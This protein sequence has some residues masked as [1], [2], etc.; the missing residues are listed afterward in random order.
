VRRES[1]ATGGAGRRVEAGTWPRYRDNLARHLIGVAR[2]LQGRVQTALAERC[3]FRGLRPSFAPF[4]GLLWEEGRPLREL[5]HEL[6]IS[7]QAAGQLADLVE[8]AGYLERRA[9]P[10]DRRSKL[11]RLTPRGRALVEQGVRL[12]LESETE[13]RALVGA[14]AFQR[15][16]RAL[17]ALYG[18]LGLAA[19]ADPR[20]IASAGRSIGVLPPIALRIEREL[21][22]ATLAR[23]HAGLKM[24]HGQVLP[25]IGPEGGRIH[26]IA[27]LQRVSRQAISATAVDLEARGY[28]RREP[29]PR[30]GRGVVLVLTSRGAALIRDS[31]AA[32]DELERRFRGLVGARRLDVL[33]EVARDLYRTLRLEAEIFGASSAPPAA[34][35]AQGRARG[36]REIE[37][38]ATRLRERLGSGDA[39]RLAALLEPP[40]RRTAP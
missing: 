24:S 35:R 31:V 33:R 6:A 22:E 16:T 8:A 1:P 17:A 27:R 38:L 15:F 11:V 25:L 3:G 10:G 5:A 2:D 21:M 4:L 30:D 29:D 40:A 23:G 19:P 9:N 39:A 14:G 32:L 28:L 20:L 18:G 36:R 34:P 12:I 37:R 13:Y 7:D 26:E